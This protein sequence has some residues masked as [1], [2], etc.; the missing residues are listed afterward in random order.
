MRSVRENQ[1]KTIW[2]LVMHFNHRRSLFLSWKNQ[3]KS[4]SI[5]LKNYRT[6]SL[7]KSSKAESTSVRYQSRCYRKTR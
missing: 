3:E 4:K 1:E 7:T 5:M 2:P 6:Q